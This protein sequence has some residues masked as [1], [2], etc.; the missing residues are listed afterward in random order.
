[1][2]KPAVVTKVVTKKVKKKN[3]NGKKITVIKKVTETVTEPG[4]EATYTQA[5]WPTSSQLLVV[6][7]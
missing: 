1:V 2:T 6:L 4:Q 7:P 5:G 3:K